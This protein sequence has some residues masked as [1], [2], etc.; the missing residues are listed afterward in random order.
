[1][2]DDRSLHSRKTRAITSTM[3][4]CLSRTEFTIKPLSLSLSL[5]SLFISPSPLFFPRSIRN[6]VVFPANDFLLTVTPLCVSVCVSCV[7]LCAR[8]CV[9]E[10]GV[11]VPSVWLLKP[12]PLPSWWAL[13]NGRGLPH[14]APLRHTHISMQHLLSE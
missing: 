3:T 14:L 6:L 13:S 12:L 2:G 1:M 4:D 10:Q 7:L 8:A 11:T 9:C 5:P